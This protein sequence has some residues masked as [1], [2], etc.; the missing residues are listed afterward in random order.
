MRP[1]ARGRPIETWTELRHSRDVAPDSRYDANEPRHPIQVVV[2]RTG[3]TADVIR[4]WERRHHAVAPERSQTSRRL[5][6][7][8]DVDRL[9][10]LRRATLLGRRIGEV[11]H[12]S[13]AAIRAL[14]DADDSAAA[15]APQP[16]R[17]VVD[18]PLAKAHLAAGLEALRGLDAA[19]LESALLAAALAL[20]TPAL[21]E[22]VLAPLMR[23][24]GDLWRDGSLSMSHEHLA[25]PLVRSAL[26]SL[27]SA[28]S[29][30]GARPEIVVTTPAGQLHEIGALMA[31]ATAAA[32]GW[33]VTYLGPNLPAAEIATAATLR[34]ARAVALSL[35][36]PASDPRLE[37]ELR[38]LRRLL[39]LDAA[40]IVG[41]P[42]ARGYEAVLRETGAAHAANTLA[43]AEEL[44]RLG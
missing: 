7:E 27:M 40:V 41:G 34:K 22:R 30:P 38:K 4:A 14:A 3:L 25:T 11:A 12:L 44:E 37:E 6:S 42:A 28:H 20:S 33:R 1:M 8:A 39:S 43:L 24:V 5:Y 31:A 21:I 15:R 16:S 10:L 17:Q 36:Y 35:V 9:L 13:S 32:S 26:S 19:R 23:S 18:H 2:R 29:T